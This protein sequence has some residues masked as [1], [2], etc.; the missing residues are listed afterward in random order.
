MENTVAAYGLY[1]DTVEVA[2]V[3]SVL[4]TAGFDNES[5]CLML[6]PT[7]P[8][9]ALVR[10]ANILRQE[11]E[12]SAATAG[13][14]SWLSGF[15][16]V[17]IP[18]VGFFIRSHTFLRALLTVRD[19]PALCGN[20]QTLTGLGFSKDD[21]S[22]FEEQLLGAGFLVYVAAAEVA[23]VRWAQELFRHTGAGES[24]TLEREA[25]AGAVA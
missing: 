9:A 6:A 15:G 21:A 8:I 2:E 22:R 14:I 5:I 17:V 3:I 25:S 24:A 1:S 4:N 18:S 23:Q 16:A 20:S 11:R 7:H 13:M 10:D 19:A 12:A